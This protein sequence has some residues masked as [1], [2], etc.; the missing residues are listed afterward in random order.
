MEFRNKI[1]EFEKI[2]D[3]INMLKNYDIQIAYITQVKED[4]TE[5]KKLLGIYKRT[6]KQSLK[7]KYGN[8]IARISNALGNVSATVEKFNKERKQTYG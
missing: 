6:N 5:V 1:V 7:W 2:Q 3:T 4:D 8:E